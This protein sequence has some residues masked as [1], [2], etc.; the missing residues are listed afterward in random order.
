M[1]ADGSLTE[2]RK[3]PSLSPGQGIRQLGEKN[4]IRPTITGIDKYRVPVSIF[5]FN[6]S[7]HVNITISAKPYSRP[8]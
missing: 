4:V 8:T 6:I 1:W 7:I 5:E 2:D 3:V